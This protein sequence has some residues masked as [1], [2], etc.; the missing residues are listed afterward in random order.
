M[1]LLDVSSVVSNVLSDEFIL[2]NVG[3]EIVDVFTIFFF[4]NFQAKGGKDERI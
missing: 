4:L 1:M 3:Q 2:W